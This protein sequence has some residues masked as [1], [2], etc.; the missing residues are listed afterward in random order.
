MS[1]HDC[2][3]PVVNGTSLLH[4]IGWLEVSS[5]YL[6]YLV[7]AWMNTL[8]Y[9]R[10]YVYSTKRMLV[11]AL[12]MSAACM[13]KLSYYYYYYLYLVTGVLSSL[14]LLL[15]SQWWTPPLRLQVS[16]CS[17]FLMMCDVPSMAFFVGHLL[18]VVLVLLL[19]LFYHQNKHLQSAC[20]SACNVVGLLFVH[21]DGV[22]LCLWATAT[23]WLIAHPPPPQVIVSVRGE[24]W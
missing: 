20:Y 14:V 22:R 5:I 1:F 7:T 13:R 4:G 23:K 15:L 9:F 12:R 16:A 18:S 3:S 11:C 24:P 8:G 17:T 6:H 2:F 10:F 19:L 21:V